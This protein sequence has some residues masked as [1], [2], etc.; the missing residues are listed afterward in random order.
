LIVIVIKLW[1]YTQFPHGY[2]HRVM[3]SSGSYQCAEHIDIGRQLVGVPLKRKEVSILFWEA[4]SI[5]Q[6]G[7]KGVTNGSCGAGINS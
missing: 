2:S 6:G 5:I 7:R 4:L 3:I 1:Y